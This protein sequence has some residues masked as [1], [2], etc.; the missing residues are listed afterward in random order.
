MK[1]TALLI[2][3]CA[4][5]AAASPAGHRNLLKRAAVATET[6]M[7]NGHPKMVRVVD[8]VQAT[9]YKPKTLTVTQT[10]L[11]TSAMLTLDVP[12][13][14]VIADNAPLIS[15]IAEALGLNS[16]VSSAA[17][18]VSSAEAAL[19]SDASAAA[20]EVQFAASAIQSAAAAGS[21][22]A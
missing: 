20:S 1:F 12:L 3:A 10:A 22:L 13:L 17:D 9:S 6:V 21:G 4:G 16:P 19:A 8:G 15:Q 18:P 5:L 2:A 7:E 11:T 14:S